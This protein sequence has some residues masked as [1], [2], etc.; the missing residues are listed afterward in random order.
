[1][2]Y[3]MKATFSIMTILSHLPFPEFCA[4]TMTCKPCGLFMHET[5]QI[6][7]AYRGDML[8]TRKTNFFF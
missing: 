5:S 3:I 2:A 6:D 8:G 4:L 1:M 7:Q